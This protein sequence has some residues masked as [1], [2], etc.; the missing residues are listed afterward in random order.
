MVNYLNNKKDLGGVVGIILAIIPITSIILGGVT[1]IMNK[2]YV[3]GILQILV[4]PGIFFWIVDLVTHFTD[5]GL[6]LWAK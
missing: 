5:G 6:T 1:R 2:H 4:L 3:A